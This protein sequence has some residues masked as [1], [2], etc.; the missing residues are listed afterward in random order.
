MTQ[1]YFV[2]QAEQLVIKQRLQWMRHH[3]RTHN[4]REVAERFGISRKTFYK[5]WKRY[6]ASNADPLSLVDRSRRPLRSPRKVSGEVEAAII[7]L[8]RETGFG[9]KRLAVQLEQKHGVR[10]SPRTVWKILRRNGYSSP[11][12]PRRPQPSV[13]RSSLPQPGDVV[14]IAVKEINHYAPQFRVV[15]YTAVDA[16]TRLQITRFYASHSTLS[17]LDF[18]QHIRAHFPFVIKAIQTR[19]DTVFTSLLHPGTRTHAFT[20][21]LNALGIEHIVTNGDPR[22]RNRK[23]L[24]VLRIDDEEFFRLRQ[25][26]SPEELAAAMNEYLDFYNNRRRST[27]LGNRSPVERLRQFPAYRHL[28]RFLAA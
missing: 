19:P 3:E 16:A 15:Q 28:E 25:F 9:P 4:V 26:T 27:A 14:E 17:A 2:K 11:Q 18:L 13:S 6:R 1:T 5:W 23:V 20:S 10:L 8:R 24:R 7:R 12:R 22:K 21:N